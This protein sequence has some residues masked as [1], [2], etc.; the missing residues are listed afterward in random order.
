MMENTSKSVNFYKNRVEKILKKN[1]SQ[2]NFNKLQPIPPTQ[3]LPHNN[4]L[5]Q[6]DLMSK[7]TSMPFIKK[8]PF[9]MY[10]KANERLQLNHGLNGAS[11]SISHSGFNKS[12]QNTNFMQETN[13]PW[14]SQYID[15][16][17]QQS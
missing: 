16:M 11:S 9:L 1:R 7:T 14:T 4:T 5:D 8:D 12:L 3:D 17:V 10:R 2:N 6:N 15:S 13:I